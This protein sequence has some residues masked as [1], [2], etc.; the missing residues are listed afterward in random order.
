MYEGKITRE[1]KI[2]DP[3][4]TPDNILLAI[5]GGNNHGQR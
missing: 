3:E 4:T 1:F 5:E 2:G